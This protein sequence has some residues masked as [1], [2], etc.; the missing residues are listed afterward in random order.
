MNPDYPIRKSLFYFDV[1][2]NAA[3]AIPKRE[4]V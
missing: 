3:T 1:T 4:A 2:D